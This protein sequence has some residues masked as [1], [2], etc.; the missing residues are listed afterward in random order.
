MTQETTTG[1]LSDALRR[2]LMRKA[3][4]SACETVAGAFRLITLEGLALRNVSWTPGQKAQIAMSEP[5]VT[6]TYTPIDWD[7]SQGRTRILC[8]AHA[9]GPGSEWCRTVQ[10]GDTCDI[11]GPRSS[12][13]P[14]RITG[15][16]AIYGDETSVGLAYAL[17][18]HGAAQSVASHFELD[19]VEATR[20]V[21]AHLNLTNVALFAR[22]AEDAHLKQMEETL[23]AQAQSGAAFVLTGR[24]QAIQHLRQA[25][26]HLQVPSQR[27][28]VKAYWA[29]GKAG[30]D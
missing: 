2:I 17:S 5:F 13:D 21:T 18:K 19:D 7:A 29:P 24:V 9:D 11:F 22:T 23:G 27:I 8:Y 30:L 14:S 3:I 4:V 16:L 28:F 1:R 20:A 15:P 10:P 25:L 6:R 12:I 26:K